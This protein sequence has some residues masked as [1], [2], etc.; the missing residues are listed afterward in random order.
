MGLDVVEAERAPSLTVIR[1]GGEPS[2]QDRA[3]VLQWLSFKGYT[4]KSGPIEPVDVA[5]WEERT[6][7]S[8]AIREVREARHASMA[9]DPGRG[10]ARL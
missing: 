5:D 4:V 6:A 7:I 8:E 9:A 2:D 10:Q 1:P 3:H